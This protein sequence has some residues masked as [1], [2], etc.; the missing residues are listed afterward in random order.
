M[1]DQIDQLETLAT[2]PDPT[3]TLAAPAVLP[4]SSYTPRVKL[5][6]LAGLFGGLIL[7]I[8]AAFAYQALD[9][10]LRREEELRDLFRIPILLDPARADP[11]VP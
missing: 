6:L 9:P 2:R 7:G 1:Q 4:T 3:M 10:R 8:R 11:P 5:S